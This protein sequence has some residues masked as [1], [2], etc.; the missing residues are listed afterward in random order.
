MDEELDDLLGGDWLDTPADF[1]ARVMRSVQYAPLPV[2]RPS[3][4][5]S[6][7]GW[8]LAIAGAAGAVQLAAFMFG[9]WAASTAG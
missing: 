5:D 4:R 7:Q 1:T 9:V 8:A 2:R 6:L 3:W